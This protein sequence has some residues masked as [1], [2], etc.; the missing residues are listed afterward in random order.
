MSMMF[1]VDTKPANSLAVRSPLVIAIAVAVSAGHVGLESAAPIASAVGHG[2][3]T[4]ATTQRASTVKWLLSLKEVARRMHWDQIAIARHQPCP[5]P[6]PLRIAHRTI[7]AIT[8]R[9]A[10][11]HV[12]GLHLIDLPPPASTESSSV[13]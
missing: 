12:S 11:S 9:V 10:A 13:S 6:P 3:S 8:H 4:R 1:G 7:P 5:L 2:G